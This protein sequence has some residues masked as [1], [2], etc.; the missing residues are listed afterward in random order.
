[1]HGKRGLS[2]KHA[3]PYSGE[4]RLSLLEEMLKEG[5]SIHQ[6]SAKYLISPSVIS[7]WKRERN[8]GGVSTLFIEKRRGRPSKMKK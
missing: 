6:L 3:I 2:F 4:F 1:M 7:N 8:Q 5:I